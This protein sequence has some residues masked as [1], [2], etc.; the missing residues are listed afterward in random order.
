MNCEQSSSTELISQHSVPSFLNRSNRQ[1]MYLWLPTNTM[2]QR[3]LHGYFQFPAQPPSS[4]S[5]PSFLNLPHDIRHRVYVLAGLVRSCPID[6][7]REGEVKPDPD[8]E[9]WTL[10]HLRRG[11][12]D[13]HARFLG[14]SDKWNED[15]IDCVCRPLPIQL[16]YVSRAISKECS[17]VFYSEN[18]FKICRSRHGGFLP[19]HRMAGS[20]LDSITSLSIRLN[21][22]SCRS[23]RKHKDQRRCDYHQTCKGGAGGRD[24]PLDTIS[25][26]DKAVISDWRSVCARISSNIQPFHLRLFVICDTANYQVA[27]E[28]VEPLANMPTLRACSIRLGQTP[29]HELR[30]LAQATVNQVT[31]KFGGISRRRPFSTQL[32]IEIQEEILGYTDLIVPQVLEW[33]STRGLI[34][35]DC[36]GKCTDALEA[37]CCSL[38]H[39]AF[40]ET[41]TCWKIPTD[42]FLIS[43]SLHKAATK[44]F[45]QKNSFA[46]YSSERFVRTDARPPLL[47]FL[48][49]LPPQALQHLR[50]IQC[51]FP[52]LST[53]FFNQGSEAHSHW[54]QTITFICNNLQLS[55]LNLTLDMSVDRASA[56]DTA[57]MSSQEVSDMVDAMWVMYQRIVEPLMGTPLDRALKNLFIKLSWPL[58]DAERHIRDARERTLEQRIMGEDYDAVLRGKYERDWRNNYPR[59][60]DDPP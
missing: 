44:S 15:D 24:K 56:S 22:C 53:N 28:V 4:I 49:S 36:C 40:S 39:A 55:K 30:R 41:C 38:Q 8:E 58:D 42:L 2:P 21:A 20:T 26:N 29:N 14:R 51:V 43:P 46:I 60:S 13:P 59:L 31:S 37:C 5:G 9:M 23:G 6:L 25:R 34:V 45:Y 54:L 50:S 10:R 52:A 16:L 35:S 7:N 57:Y 48:K 32:P 1:H 18:K 3:T 11:C 27:T 12:H 19:L 47:E 33:E 17:R